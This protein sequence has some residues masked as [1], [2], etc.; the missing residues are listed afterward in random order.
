MVRILRNM[1]FR[2]IYFYEYFIMPT[3]LLPIG[4][5]HVFRTTKGFLV[6]ATLQTDNNWLSEEII[7]D[8]GK[9]ISP[10]SFNYTSGQNGVTLN[11][12]LGDIVEDNRLFDTGYGGT[13]R[14]NAKRVKKSRRRGSRRNRKSKGKK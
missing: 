6:K 12:D 5:K 1:H 3:D 8:T 9:K 11:D 4:S 2:Q 7:L 13:R 10:L 14:R